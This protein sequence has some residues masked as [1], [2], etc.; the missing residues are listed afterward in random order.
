MRKQMRTL[1][2]VIGDREDRISYSNLAQIAEDL[3]PSP[4]GIELFYL[5]FLDSLIES[6]KY[7]HIHFSAHRWS[8]I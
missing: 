3:F 2:T 8:L 4:S 5:S 1:G 7:S 6:F